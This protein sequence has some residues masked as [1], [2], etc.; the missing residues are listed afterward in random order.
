MTLQREHL[1]DP[2]SYY[3]GQGLTLGGTGLWRTARCDFHGG[4]DSLRINTTSGGFIC[5]AGCGAKGGD[6]LSYHQAANSMDFVAAA[7]D[8][9]AW[10][11]DGKPARS[12]IRPPRIP[13]KALL[14]LVADDLTLCVL[15][16]SDIR[17]DKL[18]DEDY[19]KF[20]EAVSQILYIRGIANE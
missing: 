19:Q 7:T 13:A 12:F 11:E 3:E 9:G 17:Q 1:P 16:L 20:L 2:V 4:S 15:V 18:N 6:I 10:I 5:M 14:R 8:L